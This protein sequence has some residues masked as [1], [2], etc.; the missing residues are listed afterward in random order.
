M[1]GF[2][3]LDRCHHCTE[4]GMDIKPVN[5]QSENMVASNSVNKCYKENQNRGIWQRARG[6]DGRVAS[7]SMGLSLEG[8]SHTA[9]K[10]P[11]AIT[12]LGHCWY[13][14]Q[15]PS[16]FYP[17]D[18]FL[19]W[20]RAWCKMQKSKGHSLVNFYSFLS[21]FLTFYILFSYIWVPTTQIIRKTFSALQKFPQCPSL[22]IPQK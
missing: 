18:L 13:S 22:L 21:F 11:P 4:L 1:L 15:G 8:T 9:A 5:P 16:L 7:D 17:N 12:Y 19:S 14:E 3:H 10:I 6:R 20:S 2:G